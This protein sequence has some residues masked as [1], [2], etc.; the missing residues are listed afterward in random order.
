MLVVAVHESTLLELEQAEYN[1]FER[2][3]AA[4]LDHKPAEQV[5]SGFEETAH[6]QAG[7][8]SAHNQAEQGV[9]SHTLVVKLGARHIQ[10]VWFP[11][12]DKLEMCL[13]VG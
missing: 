4:G 5:V 11:E 6:N 12:K 10:A 9:G 2:S 13:Q 7:E 1:Q 8:M 3:A